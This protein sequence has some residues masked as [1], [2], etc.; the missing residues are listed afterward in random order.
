MDEYT[1]SIVIPVYNGERFIADCLRSVGDGLGG[2]GERERQTVEII[3]CDNYSTDRTVE[4]AGSIELGVPVRMVQPDRHRPNRTENWA[5]GLAQARGRW[6]MML[7][8][9]DRLAAGGVGRLVDACLSTRARTAVMIG[10]RH[11]VFTDSS[12]P[13]GLRPRWGV[14]ALMRGRSLLARVLPLLCP[15]VPFT[16]MRRSAYEAVGGLDS[17]YELVQDWDLWIRLL[18]QG[19]FLYV[20]HEIGHWRCHEF[21]REYA[22]RMATEQILVAVRIRET[23]PWIRPS[24]AD[25][26]FAAQVAMHWA[27]LGELPRG[28]TALLSELDSDARLR[29]LSAEVGSW[30][31]RR[32]MARTSLGLVACRMGGLGWRD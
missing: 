5:Y 1:L 9:D 29:V 7:H 15:F 12:A 32:T 4:I 19:D 14:A 11:R 26:C 18:G 24:T 28:N 6:M 31:L 21:S 13:G 20:A 16:V 10:G 23:I 30:A 17:R 22:R 3:V 27:L 8:A 2:L 25:A